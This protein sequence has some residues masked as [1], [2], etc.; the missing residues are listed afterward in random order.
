MESSAAGK[1]PVM[2]TSR[3][4]SWNG[5]RDELD[6]LLNREWL[7]SNGFGGYAS[8]TVSG[9]STRKYH[10]LLVA[11][12]P[13][14][15]GR[16]VMLSGVT[17]ELR[18]PDGST[19]ELGG[20]ETAE[21]RLRVPGAAYLKEFRLEMGLPVWRYEIGGFVIEKR[22]LLPYMQNSVYVNY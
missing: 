16:V 19:A 13:S 1:L 18:F 8:S 15:T 12:M 20:E 22:V 9:I 3:K 5:Q 4:M 17:E 11:A 6:V 21:D 14:P 7:V 10:G 2:K